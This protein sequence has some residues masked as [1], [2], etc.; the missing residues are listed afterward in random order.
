M[1]A[2]LFGSTK[3]SVATPEAQSDALHGSA[4]SSDVESMRKKILEDQQYWDA[5]AAKR[6]QEDAAAADA[7]AAKLSAQMMQDDA[8]SK[9]TAA[10]ARKLPAAPKVGKTVIS[11][12][13][14]D[15]VKVGKGVF[16]LG[17]SAAPK[18]SKA[19]SA[20]KGAR[21]PSKDST[22]DASKS[23]EQ[24]LAAIEAEQMKSEKN[25]AAIQAE[26]MRELAAIEAE[27]MKSLKAV[28][29]GKSSARLQYESAD[30]WQDIDEVT[31]KQV[32]GQLKGGLKQFAIQSRGAMYAVNFTNPEQ[33]TM[34]KIG[35]NR[36]MHLRAYEPKLP[37]SKSS[38]NHLGG[39]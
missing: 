15:V 37:Q 13:E 20:S 24:E 1:F 22:A 14:E 21:R 33:I 7:A 8:A 38:G 12:G 25:L 28:G 3:R 26:R 2:S 27:H 34:T 18:A 39:A 32:T 16:S 5:E 11:L 35:T 10:A 30:G 6:R 23:K 31:F 4:P 17:E 9:K 36:P 29:L 19:R